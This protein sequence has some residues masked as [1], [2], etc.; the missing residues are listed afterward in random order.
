ML[1]L[2]IPQTST[3]VFFVFSLRLHII[4]AA[5]I[6]FSNKLRV[7]RSQ[8]ILDFLTCQCPGSNWGWSCHRLLHAMISKLGNALALFINFIVQDCQ[9]VSGHFRSLT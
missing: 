1:A 6:T 8:E 2:V 3:S 9:V 5:I 4:P 7:W